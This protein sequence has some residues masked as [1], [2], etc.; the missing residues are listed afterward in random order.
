MYR[1]S[2]E[3]EARYRNHN[4]FRCHSL[5]AVVSAKE[6]LAPPHSAVYYNL[7]QGPTAKVARPSLEKS[8]RLYGYSRYQNNLFLTTRIARPGYWRLDHAARSHNEKPHLQQIDYQLDNPLR[9]HMNCSQFRPPHS[10]V[11]SAMNWSWLNW[12]LVLITGSSSLPA[13]TAPML[14]PDQCRL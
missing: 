14:V 7:I 8:V 12:P 6:R 10:N 1:N 9:A 2:S 13:S 11:A 4:D 3:N 5:S